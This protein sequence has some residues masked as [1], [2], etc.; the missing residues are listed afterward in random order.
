MQGIRREEGNDRAIDAN[1]RFDVSWQPAA[2]PPA[3]APKIIINVNPASSAMID[4]LTVASAN[5]FPDGI[6]VPVPVTVTRLV[7]GWRVLRG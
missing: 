1:W 3:S 7:F 4:R 6:P 5:F 2:V